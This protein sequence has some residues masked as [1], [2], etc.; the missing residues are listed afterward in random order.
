MTAVDSISVGRFDQNM[1]VQ[2]ISPPPAAQ[3]AAAPGA[4]GGHVTSS[5]QK[6][7]QKT[8]GHLFF[9]PLIRGGYTYICASSPKTQGALKQR[10][11]CMYV[12]TKKN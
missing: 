6:G 10:K 3:L 2:R 12:R 8:P 7:Q 5:A 4:A 9:R 11:K 1:A